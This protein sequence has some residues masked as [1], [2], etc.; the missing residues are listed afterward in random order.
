MSLYI[1]LGPGAQIYSEDE[2]ILNENVLQF[3]KVIC[4]DTPIG[5]FK[6]NL[7][8]INNNTLPIPS[9]IYKNPPTEEISLCEEILIRML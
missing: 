6:N 8:K 7:L 3:Q 5:D 4:D 9:A 2:I 1:K